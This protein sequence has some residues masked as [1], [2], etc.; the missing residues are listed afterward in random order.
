MAPQ[1]PSRSLRDVDLR[2]TRSAFLFARD[3]IR[4]NA[5]PSSQRAASDP[6]GWPMADVAPADIDGA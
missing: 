5:T 3:A 4:A 2:K 6:D 1:D